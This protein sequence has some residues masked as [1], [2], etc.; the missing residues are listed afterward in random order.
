MTKLGNKL[1]VHLIIRGHNSFSMDVAVITA[2]NFY[3]FLDEPI[4][5]PLLTIPTAQSIHALLVFYNNLSFLNYCYVG[6]I[7]YFV[8]VRK[9]A[10]DSYGDV[11]IC[12]IQIE[13]L[14]CL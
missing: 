12:S 6:T 10:L 3:I 11:M 13:E 5:I 2:K 14:F 1:M 9:N 8:R 7:N 4:S